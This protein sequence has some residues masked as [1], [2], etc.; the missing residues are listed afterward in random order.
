MHE[1]VPVL[2]ELTSET[3]ASVSKMQ[4]NALALYYYMN[5]CFEK[6]LSLVF[7]YNAKSSIAQKEHLATSP[8]KLPHAI[9]LRLHVH[10]VY[11]IV[12]IQETVGSVG[13]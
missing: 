8:Y 1:I 11:V 3:A 5:G 6:L 4:K 12:F 9:V 7:R 10:K 13:V 2:D